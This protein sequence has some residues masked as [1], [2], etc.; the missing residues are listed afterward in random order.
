MKVLIYK[1]YVN[2]VTKNKCANEN[3]QG[4][5]I[6][7]SDTKSSFNSHLQEVMDSPLAETHAFVEKIYYKEVD[8]KINKNI[9]Y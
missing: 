1:Y 3:E 4:K 6:I 8:K 9:Y 5:Y 2:P 7:V